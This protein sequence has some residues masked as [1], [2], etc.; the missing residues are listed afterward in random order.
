MTSK[1]NRPDADE[2]FRRL[3]DDFNFNDQLYKQLEREREHLVRRLRNIIKRRG[4]GVH[5]GHESSITAVD[6]VQQRLNADLVRE[7][8]KPTPA[9]LSRCYKKVKFIQVTGG[10]LVPVS[11]EV[12]DLGPPHVVENGELVK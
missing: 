6:I 9:Q 5:N 2:R 4:R 12:P 3:I 10:P 1:R 11:K 7:V 8:L